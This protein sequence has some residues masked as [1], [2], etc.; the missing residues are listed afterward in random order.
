MALRVGSA[1]TSFAVGWPGTSSSGLSGV[2]GD[3]NGNLASLVMPTASCGLGT[4]AGGRTI[5]ECRESMIPGGH[6]HRTMEKPWEIMVEGRGDACRPRVSA[7]SLAF[8]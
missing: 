3:G 7:S 1:A 2:K 5:E 8:K 4:L 6:A